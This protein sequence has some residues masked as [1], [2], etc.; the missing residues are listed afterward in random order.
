MLNLFDAIDFFELRI[1]DDNP[2]TKC[3]IDGDVD[4]AVNRGGND[5]ASMLSVIGWKIGAAAAET[6]SQRAPRDD[7]GA[8]LEERQSGPHSRE[9]TGPAAY[10]CPH[11]GQ[12]TFAE[13]S[14]AEAINE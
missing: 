3:F 11:S 1:R 5:E 12:G 2:G 4:V 6:D 9:K 14:N 8:D 7:H 10:K 13:V